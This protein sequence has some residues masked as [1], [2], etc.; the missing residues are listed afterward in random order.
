MELKVIVIIIMHNSLAKGLR[1]KSLNLAVVSKDGIMRVFTKTRKLRSK[2]GD[3]VRK[4]RLPNNK[5]QLKRVLK[6]K[7]ISH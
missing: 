1:T 6:V 3:F 7:Y 5:E 4:S 2:P